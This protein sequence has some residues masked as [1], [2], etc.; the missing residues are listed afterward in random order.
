MSGSSSCCHGHATTVRSERHPLDPLS[1][2]ELRAACAAV[3]ASRGD[4]DQLRFASVRLEEPDKTS[5]R[6]FEQE[7]VRPPRQAFLVVLNHLTGEAFEAWIDL[8]EGSPARL[9]EVKVKTLDDTIE[10]LREAL[11]KAQRDVAEAKERCT[12]LESD[13][14]TL[15]D[16]LIV[17][18]EN[19]AK[20]LEDHNEL[21]DRLETV[22]AS[23][24]NMNKELGRELSYMRER[25]S[26]VIAAAFLASPPPSSDMVGVARVPVFAPRIEAGRL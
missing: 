9:A 20:L 22:D 11:K 19:A 8:V 6:A 5:V 23:I 21:R 17:V 26:L 15:E 3:L 16:R 25:F 24:K 1:E 18:G 12:V 13:K 14:H 2:D 7:G 4:P 10:S